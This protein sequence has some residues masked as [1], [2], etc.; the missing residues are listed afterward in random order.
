MR[1][2]TGKY[3]GRVLKGPK[4]EGLRP[5]AD[6]VKEALFNIISDK[7]EGADFLDLFAGSGAIG[8]EALSRNANSVVFADANPASIKLVRENIRFLDPADKFRIVQLPAERTLEMIAKEGFSFDLIFLD[9]P[10]QAGLLPKTVEL[11]IAF[12]LLKDNGILIV[13]HPRQLTFNVPEMIVILAK[14]YG[15]ISLTLLQTTDK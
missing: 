8:I 9:P 12:H 2:I 14:N 7:I 1:V 11:I 10:F 6:R 13:E 3:K 15:D 5:T 4:H